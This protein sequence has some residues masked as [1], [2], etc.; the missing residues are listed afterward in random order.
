MGGRGASSGMS[1]KGKPY[2]TEYTTLLTAGN[3]KFIQATSRNSDMFE[4]MT[5]GRV[6]AEVNAQ[7]ELKRIVYFDNA[8]KKSK[9]I[10]MR[11]AHKGMKPHTHHGY[12]HAENDGPKGAA[13]LTAQEKRLVD[14]I[15]KRWYNRKRK[16]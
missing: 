16:P 1:D 10:D 12:E 3:V 2:G 4:T 14:R 8:L 7:G 6:Y 5:R 15:E 11:H 13:R 9:E